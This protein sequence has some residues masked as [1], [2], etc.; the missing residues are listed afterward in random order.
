MT[1]ED[2]I[3]RL[4]R[5]NR[6]MKRVVGIAVALVGL[7]LT[8]G[9]S[10][11]QDVIRARKFMVVDE[12]GVTR[13]D[14][15]LDDVAAGLVLYDKG[16]IRKLALSSQPSIS[17]DGQELG[18]LLIGILP[19]IGGP[20]LFLDSKSG[21]LTLQVGPKAERPRDWLANSE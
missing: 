18:N 17:L 13:G 12:K 5:Q 16:G 14:F 6:W 8:L 1:L 20:G 10:K 19:S 15:G 9:Q 7:L 21:V 11:P 2:R 4:E 3:V